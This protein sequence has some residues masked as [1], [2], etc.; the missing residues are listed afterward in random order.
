MYAVFFFKFNLD[1]FH[2]RGDTGIRDLNLETNDDTE[3]ST[4]V[5]VNLSLP[6]SPE[7]EAVI[8]ECNPAASVESRV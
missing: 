5:E 7:N 1:K 8:M 3:I 2:N 6:S 4:A